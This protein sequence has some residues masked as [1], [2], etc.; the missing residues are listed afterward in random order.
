MKPKVNDNCVACMTCEGICPEVFKVVDG[1]AT[2]LEADY[3]AYK[4]K[5]DQAIASCAAQAIAWEE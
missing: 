2:V 4:D 5:I 3:S 1:K